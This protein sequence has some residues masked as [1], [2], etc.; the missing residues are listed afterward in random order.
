MSPAIPKKEKQ[1]K[2]GE[3]NSNACLLLCLGSARQL[4]EAAAAKN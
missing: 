1:K 2:R 4:V 3:N